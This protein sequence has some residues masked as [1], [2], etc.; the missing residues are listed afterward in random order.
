[1]ED[2]DLMRRIR[3]R[4]DIICLIPEKV[5]T[6][7]RRWEREGVVYTTLRNWMLQLLYF[8]GMPPERLARFY[9]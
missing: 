5:S 8:L 6:S 3:G 4:G 7:A 9:R 2:V 1:M